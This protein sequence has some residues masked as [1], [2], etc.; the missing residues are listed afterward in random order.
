MKHETIISGLRLEGQRGI[1]APTIL[2]F[3]EPTFVQ[4]FLAEM[5]SA[6]WREKM[7]A[8]QAGD[9]LEQPIHRSFHLVVVDAR[10]L[11]VGL[12]RLDEDKIAGAGFVI[13][14][15]RK[16]GE[17]GWLRLET[18]NLGWQATPA[19]TLEETSAYDPDA[20]TRR[21]RALGKNAAVLSRV[22]RLPGGGDATDED[23]IALYPA[24]PDVAKNT[25]MTL[26]YGFLPLS[27]DDHEPQ[28]APTPPFSLEDVKARISLL[29]KSD[30][31]GISFPPTSGTI[32]RAEMLRPEENS[33]AARGR[34]LRT[35]KSTL[36]WLS[37]ETGAFVDGAPEGI[38]NT[39]N[40]VR[41]TGV[42]PSG[43]FDYLEV[44]YRA[45]ILQTPDAPS[46]VAPSTSWPGLNGSQENTL[47]AV[48]YAAMSARWASIAPL[49]PRY[50]SLPLE[51]HVRCFL[52]V[53]D[54]E[55]CPLRI[56][57]S[58]P[59]A[60]FRIK[61]WFEGGDGPAQQIEMPPV[62]VESLKKMKPNVVFNV[63]PELQQHM[64]RIN[65]GDL[66]NG[67]HTKT[68]I[69]FGMIC[70][71]SIPIITLCA[72]FVLQIFLQLLNIIFWWLPFIKICI[73]YP[74][75]STEE[76]GS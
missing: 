69:S 53:D 73:P 7:A 55:G 58:S 13:R 10:C 40:E 1:L 66:L 67:K 30:R 6:D 11:R 15:L 50:P 33:N 27:G 22:D 41:L 48:A 38:K 4:T 60:P 2:A 76:E 25:G 36:F 52:R 49:T 29:L 72:F 14:R 17:D 3:R 39:L 32:T 16:G 68:N 61:P 51:Y 44:C 62:N 23:V 74:K 35:L 28:E 34:G 26:L 57:W 43:L 65:L 56:L 18:D 5:R 64:D 46:S 12:P 70:G 63:P 20:A 19:G 9:L 8:R 31:T 21:V 71:F 42:S 24:P 75:I 59:S 45:F 37:Q 54:C 47:A